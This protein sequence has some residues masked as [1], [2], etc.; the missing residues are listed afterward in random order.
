MYTHTHVTCLC[1]WWCFLTGR[2]GGGES[3]RGDGSR[4]VTMFSGQ[5]TEGVLGR[6]REFRWDEEEEEEEEWQSAGEE[7]WQ[8]FGKKKGTLSENW[9]SAKEGGKLGEITALSSTHNLPL[10]IKLHTEAVNTATHTSSSAGL[11]VSSSGEGF[12]SDSVEALARVGAW[13]GLG[14]PPS[15]E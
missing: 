11:R 15:C 4:Y 12:A 8:S 1:R 7:E 9:K 2:G 5:C 10:C 3:G 13:A 14:S 6:G